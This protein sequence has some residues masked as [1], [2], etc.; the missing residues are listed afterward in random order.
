MLS[1]QFVYIV[2]LILA[3]IC[4]YKWN[5]TTIYTTIDQRNYTVADYP[6]KQD[7][8]N[9]LGRINLDL[10]KL[11]RHLRNKYNV[12]RIDVMQLPADQRDRFRIVD[13]MLDNYNPDVMAENDPRLSSDTS[14]TIGKGVELVVCVRDRNNPSKLVDYSTLL[15]VMLH[16][17]SHIGAYDVF[18]H[19]TRFWEVFKFV[20]TEA[21]EA[22]IYEPID[23]RQKNTMYCGLNITYNPYFDTNL[24]VV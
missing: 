12:D 9:M 22:G 5:F 20:L 7:A 23:Y 19:G 24:K 3:V 6:N 17:I 11:L 14:Y 15:F 18:G 13:N 16:E 4:I 1:R 21:V 8:A 2:L 10:I